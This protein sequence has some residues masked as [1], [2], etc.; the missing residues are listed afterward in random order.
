MPD[1]DLRTAV[2]VLAE[3]LDKLGGR[4]HRDLHTE[5]SYIDITENNPL[6][7]ALDQFSAFADKCLEALDHPAVQAI[8]DAAQTT[9]G[10]IR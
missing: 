10:E 1:A 6:Y 2:T 5:S 7:P 9:N 4:I 8:L 3:A